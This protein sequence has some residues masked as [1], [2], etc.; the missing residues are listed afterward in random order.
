MQIGVSRSEALRH[1]ADR[2]ELTE[3]HAFVVAVVQAEEHGLPIAQVLRVQATDMRVKRRLR[4]EE[5]AMRL[6]VKMIFPLGL[7]IFPALFIVII[8]PGVVRI[9]KALAI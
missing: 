6:P 5:K 2:T 8:G 4:A 9:W 1:L 3:L 7:C